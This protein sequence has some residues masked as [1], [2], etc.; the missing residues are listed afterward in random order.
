MLNSA[1]HEA[2]ASLPPNT[3]QRRKN[4]LNHYPSGSKWHWL[5]S[6]SPIMKTGTWASFRLVTGLPLLLYASWTSHS[7]CK[8]DKSMDL[9]DS[10]TGSH[11][12][13]RSLSYYPP[14]NRVTCTALCP[15]FVS[16]IAISRLHPVAFVVEITEC[17]KSLAQTAA[18]LSLS[19]TPEMLY[20]GTSQVHKYLEFVKYYTYVCMCLSLQKSLLSPL[21]R[22][23]QEGSVR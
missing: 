10:Q 14:S 9:R 8:L 5:F 19:S 4:S 23:F 1:T 11:Y 18:E 13:S 20:P 21:P 12:R 6:I 15:H 3:S 7:L 16:M 2:A 22:K 17:G